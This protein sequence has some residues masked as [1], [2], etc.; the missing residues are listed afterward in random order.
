MKFYIIDKDGKTEF[1]SKSI[2]NVSNIISLFVNNDVPINIINGINNVFNT[3]FNF[4]PESVEVFLNGIK[5]KIIT[6]YQIINNN[7]ITLNTSP[8]VGENILINYIKL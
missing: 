1:I 2:N 7:T 8:N 6:D 3:S 4:I 5:Q